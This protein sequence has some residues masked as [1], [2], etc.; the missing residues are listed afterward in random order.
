MD[1]DHVDPTTKFGQVSTMV[2]LRY[3][4]EKI[5]EET[6]KCVIVCANCH[7]IRSYSKR[8]GLPVN[9]PGM[10]KRLRGES[11]SRKRQWAKKKMAEFRGTPV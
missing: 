3:S 1:F 4:L 6:R 8:D 10:L 7:R 5:L 2:N 9:R 11:P